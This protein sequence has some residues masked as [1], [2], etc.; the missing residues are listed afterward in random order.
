MDLT[1]LFCDV[2]DFVNCYKKES[3]KKIVHTFKKYYRKPNLSESEIMT[4]CILFYQQSY[5]NFK[6]FYGE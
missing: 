1:L 5:R 3:V 2:D 6:A 4:S